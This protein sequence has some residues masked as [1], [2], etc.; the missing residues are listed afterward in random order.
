LNARK[1]PLGGNNIIS[2]KVR[3]DIV[4]AGNELLAKGL[5]AG[6]WGNVSARLPDSDRIAVTPSGHD[7][8]TLTPDD[9]VLVD[10]HGG[11]VDGRL[12]PSSETPLHIAVYKSRP[13]VKAIVHTHSTFA[14]AC[15]V[16]RKPIPP[17]IEDLVQLAGG[18]VEVAHYALPGTVELAQNAVIALK[19]RNAVLLANHGVVGCGQSLR[20]AITACE[21]VEKAAQIYIY[22]Q[23]L[24]GACCLSE[25][26]VNKMHE[27]YLN[28]YR[29]RQ[30][31]R[32]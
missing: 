11:V 5:V 25:T 9:V 18:S 29:Q 8:R 28:H 17:I 6:T 30:E 2:V 21:L 23:N 32:E 12:K 19:Q 1:T 22:A 24:G 31:G 7:Y 10:I 13:D 20:E 14:S 26:D 15:A 16:A 4:A 3:Q 27:F